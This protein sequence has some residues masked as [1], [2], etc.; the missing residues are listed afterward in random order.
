M[1]QKDGIIIVDKDSGP[2]SFTVVERIRGLMKAKKAG[3]AG[4][5]DPFASGVL[6]ILLNQGTK[7]SPFLMSQDKVYRAALRLGIETDTQDLTGKIIKIRDI[8]ALSRGT[9]KEKTR[10]F[11]G[12]I[13][14]VPP[15]FSAVHY[16]G[17]RAYELAR[18]GVAVDL[19]EREVRIEYINVLR[20]NLPTVWIE[21]CCSSGTYIRALA[22]DLGRSLGPGAHLTFLRRLQSGPFHVDDAF[23][24]AQVGKYLCNSKVN[25]VIMPLKQALKG[26]TEVEI[27][28]ALARRI[29]SGHKP[30]REE[31]CGQNPPSLNSGVCLRVVVGEELVAVLEENS[32][33]YSVKRVFT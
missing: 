32:N 19:Q 24:V 12:V 5:L 22:A 33:G 27:S 31:L 6:V 11:V 20:V 2:S 25:E 10:Q 15:L 26:M 14:Q 21:V 17:K 30:K 3:H 16:K 8:G 13:K 18:S 7:L 28:D 1:T 9:I 23:T 4:T 29:R